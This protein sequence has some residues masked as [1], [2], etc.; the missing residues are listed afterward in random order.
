MSKK[1]KICLPSGSL[2]QKTLELFQA[3]NLDVIRSNSRNY[4]AI[5]NDTRIESI[6]FLP[7]QEVASHVREGIFDCGITGADWILETILQR[8]KVLFDYDALDYPEEASKYF[9]ES[10]LG[11]G[12]RPLNEDL[13][14]IFNA[15]AA[16][17]NGVFGRKDGKEYGEYIEQISPLPYTR[18]HF[19]G[20]TQVVVA[21]I[22]ETPLKDLLFEFGS[23]KKQFRIATELQE[24]TLSFF[25]HLC[26]KL[27]KK[28]CIC[29]GPPRERRENF[30]RIQTIFSYGKTEIKLV[31]GIADAIVD[32]TETGRTL[33][34]Q[35]A[36]IQ[37]V[38]MKSV[39]WWITNAKQDSPKRQF[40]E[41]IGVLLKSALD[42]HEKK[43]LK[44]NIPNGLLQKVLVEIP[45]AKSPT[46]S[47][48]FDTNFCAVETIVPRSSLPEL[49]SKIQ[50]AGAVD[51]L[52]IPIQNIISP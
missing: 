26:P 36:F 41:E 27:P 39:P 13:I 49:I 7:A 1:L 40:V 8:L 5:I 19:G 18:T 38:V 2:E 50:N 31:L 37:Q 47:P 42:S 52:V 20:Y 25:E 51:I 24:I 28:P 17:H 44:F 4:T 33:A 22:G 11:D 12:T 43:L 46:I 29:P 15:I 21:T 3:A 16:S 9:N 10:S 35:G 23:N 32:I 45:T 14:T 30:P 6:T 34:E 48:L